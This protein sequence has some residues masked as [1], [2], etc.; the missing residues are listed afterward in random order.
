[1]AEATRWRAAPSEGEVDTGADRT[2]KWATGLGIAGGAVVLLVVA[3]FVGWRTLMA[4]FR[5]QYYRE[6]YEALEVAADHVGHYPAEFHLHNV[7]WIATRESY[8]QANSLAMVAAQR[9]V[10]TSAGQCSFLMG[11]TYGATTV[12]GS[13]GINPFTDPEPGFAVAAPYL[14]LVRRYYATDDEVLYLDALRYALS[15]GYVVRVALDASVLYDLEGELPHSDL[16][17]GYDEAGFTYYETVCLPEF[18]CEPG[19]LPPG[20][21][22]LWVSDQTLLDAVLAQA[23]LFSYPWR[24]SLTI[25]EAGP[26]EGDLGAIWARNGSLLIGGAR[27]GPRQGADA[28]D[29]LAAAIEKRGAKVDVSEVTWGLEAAV[30]TRRGN[31]AYLREVFAGQADVERAAALFDRAA[32]DYEAVL[33]GVEDGIADQREANQMATR[34]RDAAMAEREAGEIFLARGRTI[35]IEQRG[36]P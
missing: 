26:R 28:I 9:G 15:Q 17:V 6:D 19:H 16:L 20:E 30:F 25:F 31:A 4:H 10:D 18:P 11:F 1:V 22:G 13:I 8:C 35:S 33:G 5:E 14:G 3:G 34:I 12:P 36:M 21:E 27:Y 32:E 2:W 24:Y 7:P 23:T 29:E